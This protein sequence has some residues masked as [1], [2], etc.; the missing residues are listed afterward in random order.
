MKSHV[1]SYGSFV[2]EAYLDAEGGLQDFDPT[3]AGSFEQLEGLLDYLEESGARAITVEATRETVVLGFTY[4]LRRFSLEI[5]DSQ[6]ITTLSQAGRPNDRA[7]LL[8]LETS[9]FFDL[10][11]AKGL[12]KVIESMP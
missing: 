6:S 11:A 7:V 4:A 9:S 1:K 12:R 10:L 8:Q 3:F 2:N 5:D